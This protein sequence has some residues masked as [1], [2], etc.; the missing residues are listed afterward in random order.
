MCYSLKIFGLFLQQDLVWVINQIC[1]CLTYF[2]CTSCYFFSK[3]VQLSRQEYK[4]QQPT[5]APL[6]I[7]KNHQ[8]GTELCHL[9]EYWLTQK[10]MLNN[11][12]FL[13][14]LSKDF[15]MYIFNHH[16]SILLSRFRLC[17]LLEFSFLSSV[18]YIFFTNN[19]TDK[20]ISI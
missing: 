19:I 13:S 2:Y 10:L 17:S 7:L 11:T 14:N 20:L 4:T 15:S 18:S 6:I 12:F 16:V 1:W 8:S 9:G 3:Q 5:P